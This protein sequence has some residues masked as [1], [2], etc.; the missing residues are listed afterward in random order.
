MEDVEIQKR[1]NEIIN[2]LADKNDIPDTIDVLANA[3]I[4]A[5]KIWVGNAEA[6]CGQGEMLKGYIIE[7]MEKEYPNFFR[8]IEVGHKEEKK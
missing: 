7:K 5:C 4:N 6:D 3:L 1:A 8:Q 2:S